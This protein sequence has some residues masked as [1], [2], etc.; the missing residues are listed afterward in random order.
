MQHVM[1]PPRRVIPSYRSI[2]VE[3]SLPKHTA[4]VFV[5]KGHIVSERLLDILQ[6]EYHVGSL[7]FFV[8]RG[9]SMEPLPMVHYVEYA[10][11]S[12]EGGLFSIAEDLLKRYPPKRNDVF[13][14][15]ELDFLSIVMEIALNSYKGVI[16]LRPLYGAENTIVDVTSGTFRNPS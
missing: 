14:I 15:K 6:I 3:S 13:V 5:P 7:L 9:E 12:E 1:Y 2:G 8:P 4:Y 10:L 11:V 16:L